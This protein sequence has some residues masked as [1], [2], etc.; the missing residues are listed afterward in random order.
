MRAIQT[1]IPGSVSEG[2]QSKSAG[3]RGKEEENSE[4]LI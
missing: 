3:K 4:F 1:F 2:E